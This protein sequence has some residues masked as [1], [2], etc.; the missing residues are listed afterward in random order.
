MRDVVIVGVGPRGVIVLERLAAV[1]GQRLADEPGA[2]EPFTL[3]LVEPTQFGAGAVWRTDQPDDLC[4][5]TL[6][7]ASTFFTDQSYSGAG[8]VVAG[9]TFY[10]WAQQVKA[11][12]R[13]DD[14]V[15]LDRYADELEQM[16]PWSHPSRALFGEYASWAFRK[17]VATLVAT[18]LVSVVEHPTRAVSVRRRGSSSGYRVGLANGAELDAGAVVLALGWVPV[19][20]GAADA[21]LV[22]QVESSGHADDLVWVAPDSP[23]DQ[24]L[25][26]VEPGHHVLVRGMGMG[27]FD[28]MSLLTIG[29]GG[30]F[31][32]LDDFSTGSGLVYRPSGREPVLHVGSDRGVPFL[33]KTRYQSMPPR[34]RLD[35]LAKVLATAPRPLPVDT[36]WPALLRDAITEHARVLVRTRPQAVTD[37]D[38]LVP[39]LEALPVDAPLS[40]VREVVATHVAPEDRFEPNDWEFPAQGHSFDSPEQ[41]DEF[42]AGLLARDLGEADLGHDSA[43]KAGLWAISTARLFVGLASTFDNVDAEGDKELRRLMR[44]GGM[45][46][47]GPPAF[48]NEQLLALYEVG[49]VHFVGP[50]STV[51]VEDD[52]FAMWSPVVPGSKVA[53]TVLIDAWMRF[54]NPA[55]SADPL[56]TGL[57]ADGLVRPLTRPDRHGRPVNSGAVDIVPASGETIGADGAV[58]PGLFVVGIPVD[59]ARRDAIQAPLPGIDST[60]LR[61]AGGVADRLVDLLASS[62]DEADEQRRAS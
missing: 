24:D 2:V 6:A 44:W 61:E 7:D 46:G 59:G 60:T 15:P 32:A 50:S 52:R 16:L 42:V 29:R 8:P 31:E 34:A 5:N 35:T 57:V 3:H 40:Q 47:S 27:F 56:V 9:P 51:A 26:L 20:P 62:D 55:T 58:V 28:S 38:G 11:S 21:A 37:P 53:S 33:S 48:R 1:L 36:L 18:G 14:G 41:F 49:L 43:L 4:M 10:G 17:A 45:L 25:S 23:I 30:R 54:P 22:E 39:A 13:T 12:R 19:V